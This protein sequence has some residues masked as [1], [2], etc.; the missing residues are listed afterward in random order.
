[1]APVDVPEEPVDVENV[2]TLSEYSASY[3]VKTRGLFGIN[4]T[5]MLYCFASICLPLCSHAYIGY[6]L[7]LTKFVRTFFGL[8]LILIGA[9]AGNHMNSK[10]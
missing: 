10:A 3:R 6:K 4:A 9:I 2:D 1:M 7:R 5:Y 8:C